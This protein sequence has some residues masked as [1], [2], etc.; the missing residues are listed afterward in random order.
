MTG[1]G[2]ELAETTRAESKA[3]IRRSE[4]PYDVSEFR[5]H[6]TR[7]WGFS[8]A[9]KGETRGVALRRRS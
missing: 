2:G 9:R 6:Y 7:D 5:E 1:I 4:T 8:T 3:L